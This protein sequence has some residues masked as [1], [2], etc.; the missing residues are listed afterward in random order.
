MSRTFS[1]NRF[2]P[3][4]IIFLINQLLFGC[5][6][7]KIESSYKACPDFGVPCLIGKA[8]VELTT[9]QGVIKL[10][11][12]G[13][14]APVTSGNFIDLV[15]KGVFDGT[16]FHRV[17]KQPVPFVVQGGD[18]KTK[19]PNTA[20]SKYGI[21]N[22]ID[23]FSGQPRFIPLE[24]KLVKED[25]PRYGQIINDPGEISRLE[26]THHKGSVAMARSEPLNSASSQFYISLRRLPE[27]DGRYS[28]FGKVID[29]IDIVDKLNQDD[30]LIS[31][32]VIKP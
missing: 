19:D 4:L 20:K 28:I 9:N 2:L 16:I 11:L 12:D 27:L 5:N 25:F 32:R 18:P 26:L 7:K 30:K 23:E 8:V 21:G 31:A 6:N 1:E 22:Y 13:N 24:L 14:L 3:I 15:E 10:E 17:V 29:G